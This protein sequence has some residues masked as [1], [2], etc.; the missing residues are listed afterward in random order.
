MA[1]HYLQLDEVALLGRTF[2]EYRRMFAL[3][4]NALYR[5]VILDAASGVSSFCAE[6]NA[7]GY[8]I[9]ASDAIYHSPAD[10]IERKC[11]LDLQDVMTKLPPI[12]DLYVWKEFPNIE[13]LT[14]RREQAYQRFLPDYVEHGHS[15]YVP[16]VYPDSEFADGAF[17]LTLVSHLLFLYEDQLN[18]DFHR[19][20]L[21]ELL[22]ITSGEVRIYPITNLRGERCVYVDQLTADPLFAEYEFECVRVDHEF[23]RNANEM[24]CIRRAAGARRLGD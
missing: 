7:M 18:Y 1:A 5:E 21:D 23:L 19:D 12:A 22:R 9:T 8:N 10:E 11:A 17:T 16:T 3:D 2:D 24:L 20:T 13:A 6:G 14:H 4:L 15:R